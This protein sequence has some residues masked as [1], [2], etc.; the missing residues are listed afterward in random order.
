MA[1]FVMC[2][3]KMD[4]A[5]AGAVSTSYM[6]ELV[7][8]KDGEVVLKKAVCVLEIFRVDRTGRQ[9]ITINYLS[10]SLVSNGVLSIREA[11][12][13]FVREVEDNEETLQG[14]QSALDEFRLEKLNLKRS[15]FKPTVPGEAFNG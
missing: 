1:S 11:D 5:Q 4:A 6:G 13:I 7:L 14:Y 8:R 15:Q 10:N 2:R 12:C 3:M 9:D